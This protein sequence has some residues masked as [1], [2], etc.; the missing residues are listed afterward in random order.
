MSTP[1]L[2]ARRVSTNQQTPGSV[3]G[4]RRR[5]G[6]EEELGSVSRVLY[7]VQPERLYFNIHDSDVDT[8]DDYDGLEDLI[9]K[10][11]KVFRVS[12]LHNF[13]Y[14]TTRM[15]Q[16]GQRLREGLANLLTDSSVDVQYEASFSVADG[17]TLTENDSEAVKIMVNIAKRKNDEY[18]KSK[19]Y[20]GFLVC[21]GAPRALGE[22]STVHLPVLLCCGTV[23]TTR[24]VHFLLQKLFD[25]SIS[26]FQ[27]SQEDLAWICTLQAD[28]KGT[29]RETTQVEMVFTFPQ[30]SV[31]NTIQFKIPLKSLKY[32]WESIHDQNTECASYKEVKM[33]YQALQQQMIRV[34]Q[35]N[36]ASGQLVRIKTPLLT[37]TN[38]TKLRAQTGGILND[39]LKFLYEGSVKI[40]TCTPTLGVHLN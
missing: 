11:W 17:L 16:Y 24:A 6:T 4:I 26:A 33:F 14:T 15:K 10:T 7:T 34:F 22:G 37:I 36:V 2:E 35:F 23:R 3:F 29:S 27:L 40:D 12:P 18:L 30:L 28:E 21:R 1:R 19:Y 25:C 38:E 8:E 13:Q 32:L 39:V 9:G 20:L 5:T 31:K